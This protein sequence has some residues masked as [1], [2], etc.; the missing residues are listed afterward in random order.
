MAVQ[1]SEVNSV[2]NG[3]KVL[4]KTCYKTLNPVPRQKGLKVKLKE[5]TLHLFV[6][7]GCCFFVSS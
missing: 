2:S 4:Q 1:C 3:F 5:F 7:A 6:I